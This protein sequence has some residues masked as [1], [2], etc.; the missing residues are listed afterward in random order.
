VLESSGGFGCRDH[1]P[2]T[3]GSRAAPI[4]QPAGIRSPGARKIDARAK[5]EPAERV[6]ILVI[7]WSAT[8]SKAILPRCPS[9][10]RLGDDIDSS[11]IPPH[12]FREAGVEKGLGHRRHRRG[13]RRILFVRKELRR[14]EEKRSLREEGHLQPRV[15]YVLQD[16]WG[17]LGG[18]NRRIRQP[19]CAYRS[20]RWL[21]RI[22]REP[23]RGIG[24]GRPPC[25][26][27]VAVVNIQSA[28]GSPI[29]KRSPTG[30]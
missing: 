18:A 6:V 16:D 4:A 30:M 11:C 19:A 15:H 7:P 27:S 25:P 20:S 12:G 10:W 5:I 23:F 28:R 2:L 1:S 8:Q 24:R 29:A 13:T 22:R 14:I 17:A 9:E 26:A 21:Q 3:G